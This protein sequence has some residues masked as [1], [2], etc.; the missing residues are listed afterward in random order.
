MASKNKSSDEKGLIDEI[1]ERVAVIQ[2]KEAVAG[3]NSPENFEPSGFES[4]E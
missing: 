4:H 2:E 1:K 3:G